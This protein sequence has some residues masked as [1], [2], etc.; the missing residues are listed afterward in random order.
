M[1]SV[2]RAL[3]SARLSKPQPHDSA[4]WPMLADGGGMVTAMKRFIMLR[5]DG[6]RVLVAL[7]D[8][9]VSEWIG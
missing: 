3:H 6:N 8:W 9:R 4:R 7:D 5:T 2:S 1:R